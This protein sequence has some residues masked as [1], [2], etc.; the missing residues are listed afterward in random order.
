MIL[1]YN[2]LAILWAMLIFILS[3]IPGKSF[4]EISLGDLLSIDKVAHV[5]MYAG[6]VFL[7]TTG[8][9]RQY[10]NGWLRYHA[11]LTSF[12]ISLSY[13]FLLET[14]QLVLNSDR[15]FDWMDVAANAGGCFLGILLFMLIYGKE[16]SR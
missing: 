8:F 6:L 4:P 15:S 5:F 3:L 10:S 12:W 1:R 13:G 2:I 16:L 9:K 7:S 14:M 11:K